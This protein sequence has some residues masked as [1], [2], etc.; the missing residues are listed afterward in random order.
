M[1]DEWYVLRRIEMMTRGI[2]KTDRMIFTSS[3]CAIPLPSTIY[4]SIYHS[5]WFTYTWTYVCKYV[6]VYTLM[7]VYLI[8]LCIYF[9]HSPSLKQ[10]QYQHQHQYQY[11]HQHQYQHQYQHQH[12]HQYRHQHQ[13]QYRHQHQINIDISVKCHTCTTSSNSLNRDDITRSLSLSSPL[14]APCR[15]VLQQIQL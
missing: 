8:C 15:S 6:R 4:P 5:I 13:H 14:F 2:E 11:Q 1:N 7:H 10:Y 12:Q 3:V 9:P